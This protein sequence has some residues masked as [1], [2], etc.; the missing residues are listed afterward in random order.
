MARVISIVSFH[1]REEHRDLF[2]QTAAT[3]LK[4]YWESHGSDRYEVYAEVGPTGPT[5]R[6]VEVN[7]F[8]D[9]EAYR[10][11][12]EGARDEPD[13]PSYAYRH[14]YEPTFQILEQRV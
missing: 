3:V 6:V 14:L 8:R 5:G 1:C 13:V 4:P 9:R 12:S 10:R 7:H 2:L 11:L